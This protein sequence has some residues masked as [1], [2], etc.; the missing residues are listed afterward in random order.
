MAFTLIE[1]LG[2]IAIIAILAGMLLPA[3]AKAKATARRAKC[4]SNL[5]QV[6]I[7][8]TIYADDNEDRLLPVRFHEVQIALQPPEREATVQLG[9]GVSTNGAQIWTCPDRPTFP[10]YE[11]QYPQ[12]I[13][14]YQYF[15][16]IDKWKNPAGVFRSRSPVKSTTSQ[17]GWVMAAD[18]VMKINGTWGGGRDTAFKDMPPHRGPGKKPTGGNHLTM[19]GAVRWYSFSKMLFIHSWNPNGPRDAYFYQ[20]DLGPRLSRLVDK[21]RPR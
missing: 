15:G 12:W 14:G 5:R 18:A 6:G 13:I 7:G 1:R 9:L 17:P 2:V 3:L 20:E 16:G 11:P 4:M 8:M 10:Q 19:D 21:I